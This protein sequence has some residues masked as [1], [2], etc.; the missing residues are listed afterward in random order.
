M[1]KCNILILNASKLLHLVDSCIFQ[2]GLKQL[3]KNHVNKVVALM[4][5]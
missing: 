1:K 3:K 2:Q 5:L 4:T